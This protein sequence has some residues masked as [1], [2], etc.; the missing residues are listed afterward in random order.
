MSS[1]LSLG[2]ASSFR[3]G[4]H[5]DEMKEM[6]NALAV[7]RLPF[8]EEYV[9]HLSQHTGAPSRLLVAEGMSVERGQMIAAPDGYI[10][11]A[12]HA[13]V[14][15][16]VRAVELRPHPNGQRMPAVVIGIDPYASQRFERQG[17]V[18]EPPFDEVPRLVQEA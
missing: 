9:L 14:T 15:G 12:L 4:I 11:T 8:V 1:P 2:K 3:H 10:S 18:E 6:T 16:T 17:P 7:E 5:P 13:P